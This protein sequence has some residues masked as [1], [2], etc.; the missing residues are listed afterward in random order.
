VDV[1]GGDH[2]AKIVSKI[3]QGKDIITRSVAAGLPFKI[4]RDRIKD[5]VSFAIRR[6]NIKHTRYQCMY[7][8]LGINLNTRI[9][10]E[11]LLGNTK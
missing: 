3:C 1:C 4:G 10:W 7:D 11:Y 5:L 2:L 9:S 6:T 8:S